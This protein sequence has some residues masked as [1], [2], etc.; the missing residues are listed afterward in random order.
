MLQKAHEC[1]SCF[2]ILA[3]RTRIR[4]LR[5]LKQ[6]EANVMKIT[7]IA[8]VTQPTVSHHLKLLEEGGLVAKEKRGREI[9]YRFNESYPCKGCGVF[10][11]PIQMQEQS[12]G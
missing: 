9:Y 1:T 7:E 2:S 5:A 3:D 12:H 11:A 10:S 6:E 4:I 8:G